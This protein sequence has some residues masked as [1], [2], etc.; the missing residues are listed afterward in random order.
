MAAN[1]LQKQKTLKII[2]V[3]SF[4]IILWGIYD[5]IS[6]GELSYMLQTHTIDQIH[7]ITWGN[8]IFYILFVFSLFMFIH[9]LVD[10]LKKK[11]L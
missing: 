5:F 9:S 3:I 7:R 2:L 8:R 4:V 1:T 6:R 11:P 10:L